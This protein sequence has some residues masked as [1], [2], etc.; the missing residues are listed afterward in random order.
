MTSTVFHTS[1]FRDSIRL[2]IVDNSLYIDALPPE[3]F[4][5][6]MIA[7]FSIEESSRQIKQISFKAKYP[8]L[9][10]LPDLRDGEYRL[11]FCRDSH[12]GSH[13]MQMLNQHGAI[14]LRHKGFSWSFLI[15][16]VFTGNKQKFIDQSS[17]YLAQIALSQASHDM[18]S[19]DCDILDLAF[20]IVKNKA[21]NY[22]KVLALHDWVASNIYYDYDALIDGSYRTNPSDA[23]SVLRIKR[24]VCQGYAC[25]LVAL[26]RAIGIPAKLFPCFALGESTSVGGWDNPDNM[27]NTFNHVIVE[28]FVE[29]R[30][31]LIDPTWDSNNEFRNGEFHISCST[32]ISRAF[33]DCTLAFISITHRF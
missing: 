31:V 9:V 15:S 3:C 10:Y 21:G 22:E 11:D 28:A 32:A 25:L 13:C 5:Q 1:L 20:R 6:S 17:D 29:G 30:W 33:F 16:P 4:G 23:I 8:L 18:Q 27:N 19:D 12:N 24:T 14:I 7:V 26:I 2:R